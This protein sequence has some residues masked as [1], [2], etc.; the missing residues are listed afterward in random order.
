MTAATFVS[1]ML[2]CLRLNGVESLDV[3]TQQNISEALNTRSNT[4][5]KSFDQR[6]SANIDTFDGFMYSRKMI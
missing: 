6:V 1:A 5:I 3:Q 2:K 4:A